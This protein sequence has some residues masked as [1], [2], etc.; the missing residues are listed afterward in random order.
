MRGKSSLLNA[1]LDEERAIVTDIEGTTR[2]TI[3]EFVT[4][5]GIPLK[6][7]D[8]AGIRQAKDEVERIGIEKTKKQINDSDLIIAI[9]DS[10]R[11]LQQDDLEILELIKD[12]NAIIILNKE[13]LGK[14]ILKENAKI[15]ETGKKIIKISALK[16]TGIEEIYDEIFNMFNINKIQV[17]DGEF[18]TNIRHK[19]S[20]TN[21]IKKLEKAEQ[22]IVDNMPID[23]IAIDIKD[24]LNELGKI[25]G[26][27]VS[28]D[29]IK[30]IFKKFC[31]G[32]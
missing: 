26:D 29:I 16:K 25:T 21:S 10:T 27:S 8:T 6:V 31:L 15:L 17:E 30:E 19:N 32:K 12:K 18:L 22:T 24:A 23:V 20:I 11:E 7:I 28:E 5:K 1:I 4:I 14:N 2:D 13:D 9:F 3:E